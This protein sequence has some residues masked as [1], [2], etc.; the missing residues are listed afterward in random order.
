MSEPRDYSHFGPIA[1]S[2]AEKK[3]IDRL[4]V[5]FSDPSLVEAI[6]FLNGQLIRQTYQAQSDAAVHNPDGQAL[7]YTAKGKRS[8]LMSLEQFVFAEIEE[9]K[10]VAKSTEVVR[11]GSQVWADDSQD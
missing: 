10:K 9:R 4:V 6:R 8:G 1:V 7:F 3:Y 2:P 5:A 11:D